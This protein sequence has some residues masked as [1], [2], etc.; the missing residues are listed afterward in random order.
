MLGITC[1]EE[2]GGSGLGYLEHSIVGEEISRGSAS[3][4]VNSGAH[5]N[6]CMN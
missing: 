5:S 4:A 1:P 2:Y 6:L 3:L